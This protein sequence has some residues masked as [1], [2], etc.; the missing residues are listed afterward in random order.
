MDYRGILSRRRAARS[1]PE[2]PGRGDISHL[3]FVTAR[4]GIQLLWTVLVSA[5]LVYTLVQSGPKHW[6]AVALML[7]SFAV[8]IVG[9]HFFPFDEYKPVL[10]FVLMVASLA[11]TAGIVYL[12]GNRESLLGFLFFAVPIFASAYYGYPGTLLV[13]LLTAL[14]RY[15][16]FMGAGV[17]TLEHVSLALSALTYVFIGMMSCYVVEGEKMYARESGE[18]RHLLE[19]SRHRERDI[20]RIYNLSRRFS[21]TLDIDTILKTTAALARQM[22][23]AEG[24]LLFLVED[25]RVELKAALGLLPFTDLQPIVVPSDRPW[26]ARLERGEPVIIEKESLDWLP[27]PP[28]AAGNSHNLAAVPLF[29]GGDVAGYVVCFSEQTRP[30]RSSSLE[31]LSTIASQAA[32]AVEKARLYETTVEDKAKVEAIL[33]TL[34]DGL[35]L[36][37]EHGTIVEANPVFDSML[38]PVGEVVGS[39]LAE[40]LS[41]AVTEVEIGGLSL[42]EA[43]LATLEGRTIFGEMTISRDSRIAVQ[44]HLIPL[45]DPMSRNAGMVLFLHDITDLKRVDEMKSNFVS[46]V[47]HELRTPLTS[48]AGFVSLLLAGRAGSLNPE[49]EKYL[50]VVRQQSGNLTRLIENLLDLSRLQASPQKA[51]RERADFY[52]LAS[53]CC[54]Q[55][56]R[57]AQSRDIE[58]RLS[59]RDGLPDVSVDAGRISQVLTNIIDNAIKYS[60]PGGLVEV[61]AAENG[62]FLQVQVSD[63][64]IGIAPSSLPHIFDRFF[65]AHPGDAEDPT[66]F[67]L[68]L[69]ISREIIE[70]HGGRIWAESDLGRG[71]SF[72]F[73]IPVHQ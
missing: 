45:R 49:Q 11:L 57:T 36:T 67:G 40:V 33:G 70:M 19:L 18:Y 37:D 54:R 68:G 23:S 50:K 46:N 3:L 34:R 61:S 59:L 2:D 41:G 55:F 72:Y 16:P 32:M 13:S 25:S 4:P 71:S 48:I 43:V 69:A 15:I 28:E 56:A 20:S 14:V 1:R 22:L 64:G 65:Q 62:S 44:A 8:V 66:G 10:F 42:Q 31:V 5:T 30:M 53:A 12:T 24:A 7:G 73:T 58:V 47:S 35:V 60:Q 27:L 29:M 6:W 38:S 17:T 51:L 26:K 9:N 21:Y 39:P 52:E 63:T